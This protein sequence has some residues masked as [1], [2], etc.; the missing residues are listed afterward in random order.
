MF[1]HASRHCL[2]DASSCGLVS[3]VCIAQRG[4]GLGVAQDPASSCLCNTPTDCGRHRTRSCTYLLEHRLRVSKVSEHSFDI[5]LVGRPLQEAPKGA[6]RPLHGARRVQLR[7]ATAWEGSAQSRCWKLTIHDGWFGLPAAP[8][9]A[10]G[11]AWEKR[12]ER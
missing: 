2:E 4:E 3:Q 11:C 5:G 10:G 12:R 9:L 1:V 7:A 8:K 6:L